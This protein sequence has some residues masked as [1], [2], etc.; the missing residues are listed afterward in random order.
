MVR[1]TSSWIEQGEGRYLTRTV[2]VDIRSLLDPRLG[3]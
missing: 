1:I 2:I 3:L